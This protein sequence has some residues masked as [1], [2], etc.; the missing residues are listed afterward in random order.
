MDVVFSNSHPEPSD[1]TTSPRHFAIKVYSSSP[2]TTFEV[3]ESRNHWHWYW[4]DL[5]SETIRHQGATCMVRT[6]EKKQDRI[7]RRGVLNKSQ[8]FIVG[9]IWL[10]AMIHIAA[11]LVWSEEP[12]TDLGLTG[13]NLYLSQVIISYGIGLSTGILLTMRKRVTDFF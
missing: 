11:L 12:T 5:E 7:N 6:I 8:C 2:S 3:V 4:I 1:T 13:K 10:L 9:S